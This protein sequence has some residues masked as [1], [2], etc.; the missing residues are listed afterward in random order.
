MPKASR[1]EHSYDYSHLWSPQRPTVVYLGSIAFGLAAIEMSESTVLC[2]IN[3]K[4]VRDSDH[5]PPKTRYADH[6]WTTTRDMPCGRL[7]LVVYAPYRDVSWSLLFQE[8]KD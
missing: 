8:S 6:S 5:K 4:Y 2:Y 7:R 3:G 1:S